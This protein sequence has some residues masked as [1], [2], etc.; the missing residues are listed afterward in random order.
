MDFVQ[1][2]IGFREQRDV[3]DARAEGVGLLRDT[4]SRAKGRLQ[5]LA[6]RSREDSARSPG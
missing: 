5:E 1:P 4:K 3:Q 6:R 2:R